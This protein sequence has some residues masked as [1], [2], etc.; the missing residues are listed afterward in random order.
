MG[1]KIIVGKRRSG[2]TTDAILE[3]E[4]TGY[5][6]LVRDRRMADYISFQADELGAK[7]PIPV[8]LRQLKN[9]KLD[10]HEK[11]MQLIVDEGLMILEQILGMSIH[12]ITISEREEYK[13]MFTHEY[14]GKWIPGGGEFD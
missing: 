2:K 7:I 11:G 10:G 4:K 5:P 1:T 9:G 12:M 3:S 8:T 6:I 13:D 14:L